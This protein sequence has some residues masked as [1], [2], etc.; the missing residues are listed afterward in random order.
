[1]HLSW[2]S[3]R[4]YGPIISW[5]SSIMYILSLIIPVI[6]VQFTLYDDTPPF[7]TR[8]FTLYWTILET[9]DNTSQSDT[10]LIGQGVGEIVL[11][12][13]V[14][15]VLTSLF[16]TIYFHANNP[17]FSIAF[18]SILLSI[19]PIYSVFKQ[20]MAPP[21]GEFN[22]RESYS[23]FWGYYTII[24]AQMLHITSHAFPN[25][26]EREISA[27]LYPTYTPD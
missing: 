17:K 23:L 8:K 7:E 4:N 14:L 27:K 3:K 22:T 18:L 15:S 9:I 26:N 1:M 6:E 2:Y 16:S 11:I 25:Y 12:M 13:L 19:I 20:S 5:F 10:G 21:L 24:I